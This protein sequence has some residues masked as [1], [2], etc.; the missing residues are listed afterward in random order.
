MKAVNPLYEEASLN[1]SRRG[2][3]SLS[4]LEKHIEKTEK[5]ESAIAITNGKSMCN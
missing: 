5:S 1:S 4:Q 2:S 3:Y